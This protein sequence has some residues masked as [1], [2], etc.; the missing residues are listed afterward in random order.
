VPSLVAAAR[1]ADVTAVDWAADAVELLE[2]NAARNELELRARDADWRALDGDFDLALAGDVLYEQ[3]YVEPLLA[4]L[5]RLAP[6]ALV[7]E[8]G[9]PHADAF[10]ARAG[11][12]WTL[13]E[14]AERVFRL[15]RRA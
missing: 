9:R 14:P 12:T 5:P 6:V 2:R 15:V 3:R 7:A 13:D 4:V 8:P 1:G 10:F 11:E